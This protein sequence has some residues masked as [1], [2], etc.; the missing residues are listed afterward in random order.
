MFF[1]GATV[2]GFEDVHGGHVFGMLNNEGEKVKLLE[3]IFY[4]SPL[5]RD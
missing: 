1:C 4:T 2:D 3:I 5:A